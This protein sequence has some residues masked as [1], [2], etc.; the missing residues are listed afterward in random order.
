[1]S[2]QLLPIVVIKEHRELVRLQ[3]AV[4]SGIS[5]LAIPWRHARAHALTSRARTRSPTD[6]RRETHT[7]WECLHLLVLDLGKQ[8]APAAGEWHGERAEDRSTQHEA[9]RKLDPR[10]ER[11]DGVDAEERAAAGVGGD[12]EHDLDLGEPAALQLFNEG[13]DKEGR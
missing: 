7:A 12:V 1:M 2:L 3:R 6:G 8:A 4:P 11:A 13:P 9:R 10:R 5:C